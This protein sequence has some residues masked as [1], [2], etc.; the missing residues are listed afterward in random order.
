MTWNTFFEFSW[1]TPWKIRCFIVGRQIKVNF[2]FNGN[3]VRCSRNIVASRSPS[4]G[5]GT[6]RDSPIQ[7]SVWSPPA[8]R[9]PP[10]PPRN[11]ENVTRHTTQSISHLYTSPRYWSQQIYRINE[12]YIIIQLT[13]TFFR[14]VYR[15][16]RATLLNCMFSINPYPTLSNK[17]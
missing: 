4:S 1:M 9:A 14:F 8:A 13:A 5:A 2:L 6:C 17:Q 10:A 11:T 15:R 7:M 3:V 16:I 12:I